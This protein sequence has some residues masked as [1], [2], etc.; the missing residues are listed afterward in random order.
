MQGLKPIAHE[1]FTDYPEKILGGKKIVR[2]PPIR[3]LYGERIG[4]KARGLHFLREV[5]LEKENEIQKE[6][7]GRLRIAFPKTTT[8]GTD[9]FFETMDRNNL[10]KV[11]EDNPPNDVLLEQFRKATFNEKQMSD[12]A[13]ML[14]PSQDGGHA[15]PIAVRSSGITE[16]GERKNAAGINW[17][18]ML[19][20]FHP[21]P[22]V[23]LDQLV[24][25]IMMVYASSFMK[26]A[27]D[28]RLEKNISQS[29]TEMGVII[30]N[31]VGRLWS[32]QDGKMYYLPEVSLNG[33]SFDPFGDAG[34][35]YNLA[36]GLGPGVVENNK[37]S[38]R[39]RIRVADRPVTMLDTKQALES[40]PENLYALV[41]DEK[42]DSLPTKEEHFVS[43][44]GYEQLGY[45]LVDR[46][47][48]TIKLGGFG[49]SGGDRANY[50]L[51]HYIPS[52]YKGPKIVTFNRLV[53][54]DFGPPLHK[55][56]RYMEKTLRAAFGDKGVEFEASLDV[57]RTSEDYSMVYYPLQGRVQ[58]TAKGDR[59][60]ILPEVGEERTL[61]SSEKAIGFG[62]KVTNDVLFIAQPPEKFTLEISDAMGRELSRINHGMFSREHKYY[63]FSPGRV[64]TQDYNLG[65]I[66]SFET[67]SHAAAIG[68]N[69]NVHSGLMIEPSGGAH[70]FQNIL[71]M[72]MAYFS[73]LEHQ[74]PIEKLRSMATT[75]VKLGEY[76]THFTFA[77]GL[78]L[79][80]DNG[81]NM[82]MHKL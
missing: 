30:Q 56:V 75:E 20:N 19:S 8:L 80:M 17:T 44:I 57:I 76:V 2:A 64:C 72:E 28:Y 22:K 7:G 53:K 1:K 35:Y 55:V 62:N 81:G 36:L 71:D 4:G 45:D 41:M 27:H 68:E 18:V 65:I 46:H 42:D 52:D 67:I 66:G 10:W 38:V 34:G 43:R 77:Q 48:S 16:D 73:Y 59:V 15:R 74:M 79:D 26:D 39:Y 82:I 12:L 24:P 33:F 11:V 6:F 63:L 78:K 60:D 21:D 13:E 23:R 54:G 40:A 70:I 51:V 58:V 61:L 31:L 29:E 3:S 14:E 5:L 47:V 69:R 9:L 50:D 32:G 25:A 37:T 49:D